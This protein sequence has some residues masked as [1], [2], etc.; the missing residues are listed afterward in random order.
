MQMCP[1]CGKPAEHALCSEYNGTIY[2][3]ACPACKTRFDGDP[4]HYL[5]AGPQPH[6]H[7]H[8]S[9]HHSD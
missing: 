4:E 1:V 8:G 9:H 5:A 2:Y 6:E 3:F 7:H